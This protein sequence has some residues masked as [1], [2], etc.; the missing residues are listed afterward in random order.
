MAR[1]KTIDHRTRFSTTITRGGQVTLPA[2]VRRRLGVDLEGRV[3]F[4]ISDDRVEVRAP[5]YTIDNV[6]DDLPER[7]LGLT[8]EELKQHIADLIVENVL[9]EMADS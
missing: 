4:V 3:E 9:E 7:R 2:A 5:R 8:E 1:T 6:F